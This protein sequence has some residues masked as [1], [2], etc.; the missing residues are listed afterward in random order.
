MLKQYVQITDSLVQLP[1]W[2][3]T[4]FY[5]TP[6]KWPWGPCLNTQN[7]WELTAY[8]G[9]QFHLWIPCWKNWG[10]NAPPCV[11]THWLQRLSL[12]P[13]GTNIS[14]LHTAHSR[15]LNQVTISFL[16]LFCWINVPS[17]FDHLLLWDGLT[18][19]ISLFSGCTQN[20]LYVTHIAQRQTDYRCVLDTNPL[21]M[22]PED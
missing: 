22:Q 6:T 2:W 16:C 17:A 11:S 20:D 10:W 3:L 8:R 1:I 15:D 4:F 13:C 12:G 5:N 19:V 9:S 14:L 7:D 18:S 21:I